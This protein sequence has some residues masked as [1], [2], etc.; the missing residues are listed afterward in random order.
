M[1]TLHEQTASAVS[2]LKG[3]FSG[4]HLFT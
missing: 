3:A 4:L 2:G 1:P